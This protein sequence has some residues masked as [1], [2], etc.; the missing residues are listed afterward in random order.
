[1]QMNLR[2]IF[3]TLLAVLG[4]I[5]LASTSFAETPKTSDVQ[6]LFVQSAASGS[7]DGKRLTLNGVPS[8]IYFSD[9][10]KRIAGHLDTAS[11]VGQWTKAK[12]SFEADPPNAVLSVLG[13]DG[14]NDSVIELSSPRFKGDQ[15]SYQVK[16]LNGEPPMKFNTASLFIDSNAGAFIGG[17]VAGHIIHNMR[18]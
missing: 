11:F 15:I 13:E 3:T 5:G 6:M 2:Y 1:M 16:L 9:R 18:R 7:Y 10:P 8:T 4:L 17:M 14:A 12:D